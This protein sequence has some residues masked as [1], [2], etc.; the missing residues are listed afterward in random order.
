MLLSH[1]QIG[2]ISEVH[3]GRMM[4]SEELRYAVSLRSKELRARGLEPQQTVFLYRPSSIEFFIDLLACWSLNVCVAALDAGL[5]PLK[6][7]LLENEFAPALVIERDGTYLRP[8]HS[9][10]MAN[11]G[12]ALILLSS[13]SAGESRGLVHSFAA[14]QAKMRA[15]SQFI[16]IEDISKSLCALPTFFGHGLI[17]N[18]LFPLFHGQHLFLAKSFEPAFVAIL[19]ETIEK[20]S[21]S[22]MSSTPVVWG[23]IEQF[24]TLPS[25]TNMKSLRRVH[26][27][28]APLDTKKI[29][30]M[31]QWAPN[32]QFWNVYG[33]TEF[34]GWVS[35]AP[36]DSAK[37]AGNIGESWGVER[38][39]DESSGELTLRAP[40]L[41][42]GIGEPT[43]W[44]R[45]SDLAEYLPDGDILLKGRIDFLINKAGLKIQPE[46]VELI[47]AQSE[48]TQDC[49]CFAI[50][51]DLVG[52]KIGLAVVPRDV[53]T[54][55]AV[56][57]LDWLRIRLIS[58]QVPDRIFILSALPRNSRGKVDRRTLISS[59]EYSQ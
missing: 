28:S 42:L 2:S 19:D 43:G 3:S 12:A 4:S 7:T 54:F 59:V 47:V 55:S 52:Q 39:I 35:G 33:L 24:A 26:C 10:R 49:C 29:E 9:P 40:F 5:P 34:L 37:P 58:Y 41:A 38:E 18:S 56:Q 22:F 45:T 1:F 48:M 51:D 50:A 25:R 53:K 46:E 27:A 21:I 17:C 44:Y 15:L 23:L 8:Q 57:L 31:R 36:V 20:H 32:A 11:D 30:V 13:G 6:R 16:P 14:L